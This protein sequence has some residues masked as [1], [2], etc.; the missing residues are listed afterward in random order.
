MVRSRWLSHLR[1]VRLCYRPAPGRAQRRSRRNKRTA[2]AASSRAP[3]E[4]ESRVYGSRI[5]RRTVTNAQL[6]ATGPGDSRCETPADVRCMLPLNGLRARTRVHSGKGSPLC[7][8]M[9]LI[10]QCGA[11]QGET[12][13]REHGQ[14]RRLRRRSGL[15]KRYATSAGVSHRRS[16]SEWTAASLDVAMKTL[17]AVRPRARGWIRGKHGCPIA[18][19][20]PRN[21][22]LVRTH[23]CQARGVHPRG[24]Q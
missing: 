3:R 22:A 9:Q 21:G 16:R 24:D 2:G 7:A 18:R 6:L 23:G 12:A 15:V 19:I 5:F 10:A 17:V 11:G 13:C 20:R 1:S 14:R 8:R 4:Y